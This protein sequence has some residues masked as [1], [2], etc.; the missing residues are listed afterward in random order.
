MVSGLRY[1]LASIG[2][3]IS[4]TTLAVVLANL[5]A[6][7]QPVTTLVPV[8]NELIPQ[9]LT[10]EKLTITILTTATVVTVSLVP[11]FKPR[12]RRILDIFFITEKRV[13]IAC[14]ELATIGYFDYSYRLPR[15]TLIIV[16]ALLG[17]FLP[18]WFIMIRSPPVGENARAII[19]GDDIEHIKSV[20]E[21]TSNSV[22]GYVSPPNWIK[23]EDTTGRRIVAD[24]WGEQPLS[25]INR[26]GGL[27]RLEEVLI[28]N[29]IN[30]AILAFSTS[31]RAE[32]FGTLDTCYKHGVTA[33]AHREHTDS[34]LTRTESTGS[35]ELVDIALE[36]WDW[37]D[38]L[39]KR[40][41]DVT[42]AA[43]SLAVF[44]PVLI[45]I[46]LA[47]KLDSPGPVFY[48]QERTA[49]LGDTFPVYKF[50]TMLPD[51]ESAEPEEDDDN[52]RITRVGRILRKTHL[53]ELPQLWTILTGKMSVVG[54]RA[55]WTD[56]EPLLE[57]EAKTW[58]KRWFVKPGLTGLAQIHDAKSTTPTAKLRYDLEYIRRQSFWFDLK[59]VARQIWQ[60][61]EDVVV[62][63]TGDNE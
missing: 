44:G 41:F 30:I 56:E 36:P 18:L 12:P 40:I 6:T 54:P 22:C 15:S 37:Q 11:M 60:V 49:E 33:K 25:G 3:A 1:R 61:V 13:L 29:D 5:P 24:G 57:A 9:V 8:V 26:L 42:F 47:V 17:L 38:Y 20:F 62:M 23:D 50:R 48:S 35:D 55:V 46:A 34:V 14:C 7:Q 2:G 45:V 43:V 58:R 59:I 31:D 63:G 4:L 32:F 39:F 16:T 19:V 27:S 52:D 51:S 21:T 10:M 53:D 28:E